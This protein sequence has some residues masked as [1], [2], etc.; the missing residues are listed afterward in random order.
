MYIYWW[1]E[2][3]RGGVVMPETDVEDQPLNK[4]HGSVQ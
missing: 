4:M 2:M 1:F 3:K